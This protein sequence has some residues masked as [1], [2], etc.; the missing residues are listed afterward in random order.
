MVTSMEELGGVA[1]SK[2]VATGVVLVRA[3]RNSWRLNPTLLPALALAL[4]PKCPFCFL[5]Y[6][7]LLGF[8][9]V[10]SAIY[11][12]WLLPSSLAFLALAVGALAFRA[13]R[14]H[15]YG[16][17]FIGLTAAIM[18]LFSK[19]YLLH[20]LGIYSGMAFL[21]AASLWNSWPKKQQANKP[22]CDC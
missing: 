12:A 7:G 1:P 22:R 14:R 3:K 16:P 6:F 20:E 8:A 11:A 10:G 21:L 5:A 19:F 2:N 4:L 18:I 17:F 15:G 13:S 9:G